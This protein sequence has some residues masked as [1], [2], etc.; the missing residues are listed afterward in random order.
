L[1]SRR[2]VSVPPEKQRFLA[3]KVKDAKACDERKLLIQLKSSMG[4]GT[5]PLAKNCKWLK[6]GA[7]QSKDFC[8]RNFEHFKAEGLAGESAC[9]TWLPLLK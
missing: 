6:T 7:I 5:K 4:V 9:P 1:N 8:Q 2:E 3:R